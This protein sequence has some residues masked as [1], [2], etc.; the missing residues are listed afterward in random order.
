MNC[1][2][3]ESR[4]DT[5]ARGALADAG[6]LRDA[7]A[8]EESCAPCAAR[9]ADERAL[10]TG[11]RALA[12][13]MRRAEAPARAEA[14]LLA[15]FRARAA[16][17]RRDD[18]DGA[19]VAVSNVIPLT[20]RAEA[21]PWSWAKT[22]AVASLAAAASL[23]LFVLVKPGAAGNQKAM[24]EPPPGAINEK[25]EKPSE[26]A[27]FAPTAVGNAPSVVG[28]VES[29][30]P[31]DATLRD[32]QTRETFTPRGRA[33]DASYVAGG[34]RATRTRAA[35]DPRPQE[36]AT[37]FI[38]LTPAGQYAQG[39]EGHIVRV[40][41]PRSALASFGMPVNAESAGGRVKAD[42]LLGEDGV[43]RAI[44]FIR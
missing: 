32:R 33:L 36:I 19:A 23:A 20:T 38:A 34:G 29:A 16:V 3:F 17:E 39:E 1:Q 24:I 42:V 28:D 4:V 8:H 11:L 9:L 10:S 7:K 30:A 6:A 35:A 14:A 2:E 22:A 5:L 18:S 13:G 15:S 25:K 44:R 40:E 21:R 31:N 27:A 37:D 26:V 12:E 41:L 43:A